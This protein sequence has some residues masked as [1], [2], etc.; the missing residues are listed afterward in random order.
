MWTIRPALSIVLLGLCLSACFLPDAA[1]D[2]STIKAKLAPE[3]ASFSAANARYE[4]SRWAQTPNATV[5]Q[6]AGITK[7]DL[8]ECNTALQNLLTEIDRVLWPSRNPA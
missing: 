1:A 6:P 7:E 5:Y 4:K 3:L 8:H 2:I